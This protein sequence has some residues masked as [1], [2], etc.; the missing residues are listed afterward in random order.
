VACTGSTGIDGE[1][2]KSTIRFINIE[3]PEIKKQ[4]QFSNLTK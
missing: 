2:D 4:L 1:L 3:L